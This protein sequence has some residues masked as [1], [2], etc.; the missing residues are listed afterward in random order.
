MGD[1]VIA[2]LAFTEN[3]FIPDARGFLE[4]VYFKKIEI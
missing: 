3:Q 2:T 1:K 4:K